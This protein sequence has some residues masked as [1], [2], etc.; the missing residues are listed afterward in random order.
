MIRC[1][2]FG[3][4]ERFPYLLPCVCFCVIQLICKMLVF[5]TWQQVVVYRVHIK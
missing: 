5:F 2:T 4:V 3:G 1:G